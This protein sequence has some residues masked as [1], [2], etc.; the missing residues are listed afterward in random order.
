MIIGFLF[1][2][3]CLSLPFILMR[4]QTIDDNNVIANYTNV[5]LLISPL[6][7]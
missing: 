1:N 5:L 6:H 3:L 7:S 2:P 4:I